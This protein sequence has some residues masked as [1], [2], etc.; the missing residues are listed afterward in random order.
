M[1]LPGAKISKIKALGQ[2]TRFRQAGYRS[3]S[4]GRAFWWLTED[5]MVRFSRLA[6]PLAA[7][8]LLAGCATPAPYAPRAPGQATGYTDREL[9]PTR[10]RITF[11]GNSSTSREMVEDYLLLRAAEVTEAAGYHF[12]MFDSRDTKAMTRYSTIPEPGPGPGWGWWGGPGYWRF[13]PAWGYGPFGPDVDIITTTRYQA[14]AEI[15]L[16]TDDQATHEDRAIN[17]Q[18]IIAHLRPQVA[19]PPRP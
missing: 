8:A 5:I 2:G 3:I 6:G 17:A 11:T 13:R 19:P 9:T 7:L 10:Y 14:F 4:G 16:L 18:Q 15:V 12:F 1:P